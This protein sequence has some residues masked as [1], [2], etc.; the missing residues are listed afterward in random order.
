MVL[1]RRFFLFSLTDEILKISFDENKFITDN[2]LSLYS[3][4][5]NKWQEFDYIISQ[6]VFWDDKKYSFSKVRKKKENKLFQVLTLD[7]II[8]NKKS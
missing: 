4:Q 2:K 5:K 1:L 6:D 7:K 3:F 8:A